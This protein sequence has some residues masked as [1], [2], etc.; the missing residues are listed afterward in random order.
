MPDLL[1]SYD[2]FVLT[3]IF[4]MMPI[5]L[6]EAIS[7]GLPV[8]T[9]NHPVLEWM[10]GPGGIRPDM[11]KEGALSAALADVTPE[12]IKVLGSAAREHAVANYSETAVIAQYLDYYERILAK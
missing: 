6:L 8:I 5:A 11:S 3:S 4:E 1:R 2:A 9:N 7:A 12:T 10:G